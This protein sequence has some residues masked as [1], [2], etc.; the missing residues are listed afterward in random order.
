MLSLSFNHN[1]D[2]NIHLN[3]GAT[4]TALLTVSMAA[5]HFSLFHVMRVFLDCDYPDTDWNNDANQAEVHR[6]Y[7]LQDSTNCDNYGSDCLNSAV[8]FGSSCV[9]KI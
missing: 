1:S 7:D 6:T 9:G 2:K 3:S 5:S 4:P 8:G